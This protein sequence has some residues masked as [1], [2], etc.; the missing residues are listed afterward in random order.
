MTIGEV[1]QLGQSGKIHATGR[2][3]FTHNTGSFGE[4]VKFAGLSD[5][6]L[7]NEDNQNK[8]FLAF[9]KKYGPSRWVGLN[10]ASASEVSAVQSAFDTWQP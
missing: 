6:D 3:Q 7:F 9:G 4:A 10:Y 2:Y 8:M 1:R 5:D